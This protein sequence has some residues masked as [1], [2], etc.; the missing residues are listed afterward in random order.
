[1]LYYSWKDDIDLADMKI[2][3]AGDKFH[4]PTGLRHRAVAVEDT[5]VFEF[6]TEHFDFD[7]IRVEKGD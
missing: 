3:N 6:S 4:I 7:S 2:L 1:M 5:Q